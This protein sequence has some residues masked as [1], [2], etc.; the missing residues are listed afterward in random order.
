[1]GTDKNSLNY[2]C[3]SEPSK[4][5]CKSLIQASDG[6]SFICNNIEQLYIQ[7]PYLMIKFGI[8]KSEAIDLC[9]TTTAAPTTTT[10]AAPTTTTTTTIISG[11]STDAA[12]TTTAPSTTTTAA[13]CKQ[14]NENGLL[15][16]KCDG[17]N[18]TDCL[19]NDASKLR[20]KKVITLVSIISLIAVALH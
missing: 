18:K 13:P 7:C 17:T 15:Y 11:H 12:P 1:M 3:S 2:F 19:T 4:A 16:C 14:R 20:K 9:P 8:P 6:L 10:T 5:L